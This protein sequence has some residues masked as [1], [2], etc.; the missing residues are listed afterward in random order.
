[1][2]S[3]SYSIER[4]AADLRQICA[5]SREERQIL[6]RARPLVRQAALSRDAWLK[7]S[8]YRADPEQGFGVYLL[9]EERDHTLA[10]LA[11]SW[12]PNRGT[13]P[14]NHGTWGLVAGV[15][16]AEENEFFERVDDGSRLGYARLKKIG[17]KQFEVGDVVA[18]PTP[19]IHSVWNKT[20]KV[21]LSLHV[22]GKHINFTGRS[23]FDLDTSTET[24]FLLKV[25]QA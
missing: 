24:P 10:I 7:Q 23:Q 6:S 16:G 9:H 22:Y 5:E 12:L 11:V 2:E 13:P 8:M 18:M 1:M 19:T 21:T 17:A 4:L 15:D 14:H 20:G 25:E 3:D